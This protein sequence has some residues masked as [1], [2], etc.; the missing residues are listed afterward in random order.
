MPKITTERTD[1][2]RA[3][4][5]RE[6]IDKAGELYGLWFQACLSIAWIFGK[7]VSEIISVKREHCEYDNEFLYIRFRVLKKKGIPYSPLKRI[8]VKHPYVKYIIQHLDNVESGFLFTIEGRR[9]S[10]FQL[11]RRLKKC[12]PKAWFH[13][14]RHSLATLMAERDKSETKLMAWFDWDSPKVAHQYVMRGPQLTED[15]SNRTW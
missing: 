1:I 4:E 5:I 13:L 14:F 10:R 7:R 15:L 3:N 12:N 9:A 8:T 6:T 11:H 2:L